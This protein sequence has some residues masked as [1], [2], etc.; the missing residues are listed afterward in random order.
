MAH[1]A[2]W[3]YD[4]VVELASMITE[5]PVVGV[6]K[7]GSIPSPQ[8]QKMRKNL[9]GSVMV[10]SAK[11]NLLKLAIEEAE[12]KV[13]GI[14]ALE[15]SLD[16]QVALIATDMNPFKLFKQLEATKSKAPAKGGQI[17]PSDITVEAGETPFKPGPIV[18]EL[19]KAGIPAAIESGKVVIK[20]SKLLVNAGDVIP[21]EVAQMLTRLDI[22]PMEIGLNLQ[23]VFEGGI[24]FRPETLNI[25][26][27][28]FMGEFQS[29]I[30]G[31]F[32]LAVNAAVV[33][34][35]TV[36]TLVQRAYRQ[37][38]ALA[39]EANILVPETVKPMLA[40][41]YAQMLAVAGKTPDTIDDDLKSRLGEHV[42]LLER[43]A[44]PATV[45][46]AVAAKKEEKKE[47]DAE[48]VSEEDAA[49]GL[50]ALFG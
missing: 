42:A 50:G 2:K 33:N 3:K 20:K 30:A 5:N 28:A 26:A 13:P 4:E 10:R 43:T 47:E 16:G 17:A 40:K 41:A 6:I 44:G 27:Q 18:G 25:D 21:T 24:F 49:A 37:S 39:M 11:N 19:Q 45:E 38:V 8:M 9:R 31:A 7:I 22:F 36:E 32:N 23:G 12:K 15:N 46:V 1:V 35:A 34:S 14:K 29:A 48:E